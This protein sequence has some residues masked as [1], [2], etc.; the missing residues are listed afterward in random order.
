MRMLTIAGRVGSTLLLLLALMTAMLAGTAVE[1]RADRCQ[2]EELLGRR[3]LM[4]EEDSP[5]C[6]TLYYGT[7]DCY[8][9]EQ[10]ILPYDNIR[11]CRYQ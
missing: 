8:L 10:G 7:P 9:S 3:P 1:A 5:V 4:A 2:P 11:E 6:Y